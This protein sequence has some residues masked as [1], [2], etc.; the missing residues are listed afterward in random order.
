MLVNKPRV[1]VVGGG[2]VGLVTAFML[3]KLYHVPTRV[4]ERQHSPTLH[5]QAHFLNLRTM[6]ILYALMP[7]FHDRLLEQAAPSILWRDYVYCTGVG[8]A[9]EIAHIDQFGPCILR[10][11]IEQATTNGDNLRKS[12]TTL[13]P[14]QFLHF[15]QNRFETLLNEFLAENDLLVERGVELESLTLPA[16]GSATQQ[17]QVTLRHLD[18]DTVEQASYDFIL[19]A[20]GAHSLV[21]QLCGIGM[22]GTL[23]LQSIANVHFTSKALSKAASENPA[24]LYF[25]FNKEIVGVLIAH[26][27]YQ[28]EWVFQI[29]FFPPQ[30]SIAWDFS[31]AQC[32]EIIRH[33]L[34]KHVDVSNDDITIRSVGQWRMGARV[35]EL[36]D[37]GKQRVFLVGDAAH[38][39]PPAGGFG[40]NTGL[41]DAHNLVWKVAL[42]IQ[43]NTKTFLANG[44]NTQ[45]LLSSYGR[46]RQPVAKINTQLSLRNVNRTMKVPQALNISYDNA[47]TLAKVM[48]SEPMQLLPMRA[49]RK[50]AQGIMRVGKMPLGFLDEAKDAGGRGSALG[51][52]MRASVK[53]VVSR[54]K[55]LG[56]IFYHF[57]IGFSYDA[58]SW[59]ARAKKLME[60]SAMDQSA[61][62]RTDTGYGNKTIYSPTFCVGAR[63]PHFWCYSNDA[64]VSTLDMTRLVMQNR[65]PAE[66]VGNVQFVLVV[67]ERNAERVIRS[68][69]SFASSVMAKYVSLIVMCSSAE[70]DAAIVEAQK[71]S[72]FGS[73]MSLQV[74][75]GGKQ[76]DVGEIYD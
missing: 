33:I 35:A 34:P 69:S 29:P 64:K 5:P 68:C 55:T 41:Q 37:A 8:R 66:E 2:P 31:I 28:G 67:G 36:Y 20:D 63:F 74:V 61:E 13:S 15:P 22:A 10:D 58:S 44:V 19:G 18:T 23:N 21:R 12:L 32:K 46:E 14:T 57:D 1:L 48:N 24:M 9:R 39:F 65:K 11:T 4:V 70:V 6:E 17:S 75:G 42:A 54:R 59:A 25:V 40:M 62:F 7:Q 60:D 52:R 38:Q 47:Q 50:I 73:V 43:M 76:A 53:D 71:S 72:A 51:N 49:Q 3:E 45:A 26:D 30:E 56:M 27:L 16:K